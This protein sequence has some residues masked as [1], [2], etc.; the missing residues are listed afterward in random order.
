MHSLVTD[1]FELA[2]LGV[3]IFLLLAAMEFGKAARNQDSAPENS[4][5]WPKTAAE[6]HQ[7]RQLASPQ[8]S[9]RAIESQIDRPAGRPTACPFEVGVHA[10]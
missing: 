5:E 2:V 4:Q 3:A 8:P 10:A 6:T 7:A 1:L 9:D